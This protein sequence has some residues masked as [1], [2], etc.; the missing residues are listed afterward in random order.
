MPVLP[1]RIAF[2]LLS[3][4]GAF[5]CDPSARAADSGEITAVCSKVSD[6]YV[7]TKLAD[8][9]FKQE[10]Y[11][12]GKGG[13]LSGAARD[14]TID[15]LDFLKIAHVVAF[16]LANQS[17]I[18]AKDPKATNLL[19]MVY[20]GATDGAGAISNSAPY[21]RLQASQVK[22]AP[23]TSAMT[24]QAPP[25]VSMRDCYYSSSKMSDE[26]MAREVATEELNNS[27]VETA[28]E[29]SQ[30][31]QAD[32]R[33]A[34][35]LGYDAELAA[36]KGLEGTPLR[37]SRDDLIS[38]LEDSRY[39]VVLMAF[40]F[41]KALQHKQHE[42]LWVT[43]ISVRARGNDFRKILPAMTAYASQ[44][45]GEDTHGLLRKPMPEGRIEVGEPKSLGFVTK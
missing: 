44:Y 15:K 3:A 27:L 32:Q 11:A 5:A 33:T 6:R 24:P 38:E 18:P 19:I 40:D 30:R 29:D 37:H 39:F 9:T 45:F 1:I 13:Y 8:G 28:L 23:A 34:L 2:G 25:D 35:L 7:R 10:T 14:E 4:G 26:V 21:L 16:P 41:Q 42:L 31:I 20:W 22:S 36:T 12:F 17:Y 43:R